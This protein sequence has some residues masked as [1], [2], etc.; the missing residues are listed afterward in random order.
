LQGI[1]CLLPQRVKNDENGLSV[2]TLHRGVGGLRLAS[3]Q[4]VTNYGKT[5]VFCVFSWRVG[6]GMLA[7]TAG[8]KVRKMC[9]FFWT[10]MPITELACY[11][12]SGLLGS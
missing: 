11:L 12:F 3:G 10:P 2:K 4:K 8:G 7:P 6:S 5:K 1:F 9:S